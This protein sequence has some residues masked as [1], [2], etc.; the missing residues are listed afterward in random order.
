ML[1]PCRLERRQSS[2]SRASQESDRDSKRREL[3]IWMRRRQREQ[4]AVYHK[5]RERL[6]ER[7]RQPFSRAAVRRLCLF[8][9]TAA[10]VASVL[11]CR[12]VLILFFLVP[13]AASPQ[14]PTNRHPMA[15]WRSREE[16]EKYAPPHAAR[17][18]CLVSTVEPSKH[19]LTR[20]VD[21]SGA[22][23]AEDQRGLVPGP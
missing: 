16:R 18:V 8:T 22:L 11:L 5:H 17:S 2:C 6:R 13:S 3:R 15:R 4:L 23:Q 14:T 12:R 1:P 20:Q 7:E 21:A 9:F 10:A 19:L